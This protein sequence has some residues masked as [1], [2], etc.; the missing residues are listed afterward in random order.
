[1]AQLGSPGMGIGRLGSGNL[2]VKKTFQFEFIITTAAGVIPAAYVRTASKPKVTSEEIEVPFLNEVTWFNGRARYETMEVE[3]MDTNDASM[4]I[5]LYNWVA[6]NSDVFSPTR[7]M[8]SRRS[9]YE[10]VG[11]M[12]QYDGCGNLMETWI[13]NNMFPINTDFGDMSYDENGYVRI[14]MTLRYSNARYQSFCPAFI[15]R[16]VCSPCR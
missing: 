16:G 1:M 3:Y 2:T 9:D 14:R 6:S 11:Q 10:G 8:G 15:P 7:S 12:N 13:F 5:P 4:I